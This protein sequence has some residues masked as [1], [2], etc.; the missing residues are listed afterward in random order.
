MCVCLCVQVG[1]EELSAVCVAQRDTL[2]A[3]DRAAK[4]LAKQRALA[5]KSYAADRAAMRATA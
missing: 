1:D 2:K 5:A 3:Q 4:Q